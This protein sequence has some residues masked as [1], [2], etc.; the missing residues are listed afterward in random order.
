[1]SLPKGKKFTL[2]MLNAVDDYTHLLQ[3]LGLPM[4][5]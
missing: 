2:K 5:T 3:E 4:I 1:M